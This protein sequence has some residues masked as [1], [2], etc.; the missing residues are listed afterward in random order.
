M[1]VSVIYRKCL[2]Y[3][4]SSLFCGSFKGTPRWL[5]GSPYTVAFWEWF[6][7][8]MTDVELNTLQTLLVETVATNINDLEGDWVG[9]V[10]S[11]YFW[12]VMRWVKVPCHHAI[13]PALYHNC[14]HKHGNG[15][16]VKNREELSS[17]VNPYYTE[18]P[19]RR[20]YISLQENP[21]Y[22]LP[23]FHTITGTETCFIRK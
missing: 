19:L 18:V 15:R 5:D 6:W 12:N 2:Q 10:V 1:G 3:I 22:V 8:N 14:E 23:P 13:F 21:N 4:V 7:P 16:M 11:V 20:I 17:Y 9:A